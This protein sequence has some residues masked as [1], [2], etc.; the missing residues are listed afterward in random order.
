[1]LD[2][3]VIVAMLLCSV[4]LLFFNMTVPQT[5][6]VDCSL[7]SFHPDYTEKERE[8]CRTLGRKKNEAREEGK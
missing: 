5:R 2:K 3:I 4:A 6:Y 1:M 7:A 8:K